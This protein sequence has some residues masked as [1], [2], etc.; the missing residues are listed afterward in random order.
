MGRLTSAEL[1]ALKKD[2]DRMSVRGIISQN[3]ILEYFGLQQYMN[4]K[5]GDRLF[6]LFRSANS[7][8]LFHSEEASKFLDWHCFVT[9]MAV[10]RQGT[11]QEKADLVY[12]IFD[13]DKNNILEREEVIAFYSELLKSLS[14]SK[15][16]GASSEELKA[17]L[18]STPQ[19]EINHV[20]LS[21]VDDIFDKYAKADSTKI[22]AEEL[23]H[24]LSDNY[25]KR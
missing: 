4:T 1:D 8:S 21:I 23:Q 6:G 9:L 22:S 2:F 7:S 25:L 20:V 13:Q 15:V 10:I 5:A 12:G 19:T 16:Q 3:R 17:L 18:A 11:A 24:Y 14:H